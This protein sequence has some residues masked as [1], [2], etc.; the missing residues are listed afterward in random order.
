MTTAITNDPFASLGGGSTPQTKNGA[1]AADRFLKLLVTQMQ[2][3][4]PLNPLDNAQVTSQMAQINTVT[5]I[6][7]LNTTVEALNGQFAQ[8]QAM[9]GAALVGHGVTLVGNR[10]DISGGTGVG[11]F[12]LASA[13]DKVKVEVLSSAG[14]VLDTIDLGS[15]GAGRHGFNWTPNEA[16]TA[17]G[18]TDGSDVSFRVVAKVGTTAVSSTP[19]MLDFVRA[20]STQ[21]NVLTL[22]TLYSGDIA[23]GEVKAFN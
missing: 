14:R 5:G 1:D 12:D 8:M 19:L 17:I 4:D 11:G 7:K 13:A 3:Q 16:A 22:S 10:L 21:G 20:V 2:N 23:Y 6:E 18:I 9:Q 15:Q